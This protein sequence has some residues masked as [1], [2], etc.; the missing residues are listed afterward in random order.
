MAKTSLKNLSNSILN[1]FRN[2]KSKQTF[3]NLQLSWNQ[4]K[5]GSKVIWM[6]I[7][8]NLRRNTLT[9]KVKT[10]IFIL[11]STKEVDRMTTDHP[12]IVF[13]TKKS[14]LIT[15]LSLIWKTSTY[16]LILTNATNWL[17]RFI[18]LQNFRKKK[19]H[20]IFRKVHCGLFPKIKTNLKVNQLVDIF[21]QLQREIFVD[22]R[23]AIE[24]EN[25]DIVQLVCQNFTDKDGN[26][27]SPQ[28]VKT[29]LMPSKPE[30][31]PKV[32][33]LWMLTNFFKII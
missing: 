26:A 22:S 17:M 7:K 3:E 16:R 24:A 29:I 14:L 2:Q 8:S 11:Q 32:L 13:L 6:K 30:K 12:K 28:T 18:R 1:F 20:R 10:D 25:S 4:R 27:I 9:L 15:G 5:T 23:P 33:I 19:V 21:I 31:R